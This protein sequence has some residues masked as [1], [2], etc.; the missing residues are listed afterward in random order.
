MDNREVLRLGLELIENAEAAYL[1]TVDNAGFPQTRAML[2]LRNAAQYPAL[3]NLFRK[4]RHDCAVYFTTNASSPKMEQIGHNRAV[5]VYYCKPGEWRGLMLGG[6]MEIVTDPG[7]KRA[8]W[9]EGWQMYYPGGHD[10]PDYAILRLSPMVAKY[11]HQLN[12][13]T[14]DFGSEQ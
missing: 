11:Y 5:S 3:T 14:F 4:H 10:D 2:N 13:F 12:Y 7:V 6:M 9:Q 1:T 8:L